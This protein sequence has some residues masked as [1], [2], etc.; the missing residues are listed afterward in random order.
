MMEHR[1]SDRTFEVAVCGRY[2]RTKDSKS[3]KR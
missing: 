3:F 1:L 2:G